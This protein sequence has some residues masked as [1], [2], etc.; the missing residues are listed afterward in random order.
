MK[1]LNI[2]I[3]AAAGVSLLIGGGTLVA[4]GKTKKEKAAKTVVVNTL[5]SGKSVKGFA[6]PVPVE[7]TV[8]NGKIRAV[9]ALPNHETPAY[10]DKVLKS[11]IL[12]KFVGMTP[13]KAARTQV[14]AVS[15]ATYSSRALIENIHIAAREAAK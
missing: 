4:T 6:G 14:D 7:M 5:Q 13:A 3:T 9:R 2:A 15:G 1:I 8:A 11:G 10:F 12:Q